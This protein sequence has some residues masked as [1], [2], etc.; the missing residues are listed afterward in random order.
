MSLIPISVNI[1]Y[2]I[3][4]VRHGQTD[5]N[6]QARFQ[7]QTDLELNSIGIK[8]AK[9]NAKSIANYV[10]SR[11]YIFNNLSI[12]TSPLKRAFDTSKYI[13]CELS[14]SQKNIS[15][16][17][18]LLEQNYGIWE[19]L[20][21]SEIEEMYGEALFKRD[22]NPWTFAPKNGEN[23]QSVANR[24]VEVIHKISC[25]TIIVTH[26]GNLLALHAILG[27]INITKLLKEK[28]PHN[29]VFV[30]HNDRYEWI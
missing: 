7:G 1:L 26:S 5:W 30:V 2:T 28:I 20:T 14:L 25:P 24:M 3:F 16:D 9:H 6:K 12:L 18:N 23:L 22:N 13:C 15:I 8:Q 11:D 27:L 17:H 21:R 10:V 29:R 19:G 4:F